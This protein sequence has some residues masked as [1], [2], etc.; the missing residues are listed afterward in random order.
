LVLAYDNKS[1]VNPLP[2]FNASFE[3][4]KRISWHITEL[5]ELLKEGKREDEARILR[6]VQVLF[7]ELAP[8]M[9]SNDRDRIRDLI[10]SN[11]DNWKLFAEL[12]NSAHK[13]GLIMKDRQV[14][15]LLSPTEEW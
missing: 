9:A 6:V 8:R 5:G 10:N 3:F 15:D 7:I 12:N 2:E 1:N 13:L 14:D 11:A 4:L